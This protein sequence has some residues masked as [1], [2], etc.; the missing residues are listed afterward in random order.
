M[1]DFKLP[2]QVQQLLND[3]CVIVPTKQG[4]DKYDRNGDK[5]TADSAPVTLTKVR[6]DES[7][8]LTVNSKGNF[9]G[10]SITIFYYPNYSA[11]DKELDLTTIEG[12]TI[13][14]DDR[15]CVVTSVS[16][17]KQLV[18]NTIFSYEIGVGT[19]GS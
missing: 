5:I 6:I 4:K 16:V 12:A 2:K 13:K 7:S 18:S 19:S 8:S 9:S 10:Q 3:T 17:N 14:L 11:M 1:R 15:D